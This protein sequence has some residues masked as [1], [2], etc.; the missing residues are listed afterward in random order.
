[1]EAEFATEDIRNVFSKILQFMDEEESEKEDIGQET[2][3]DVKVQRKKEEKK[4][5]KEKREQKAQEVEKKKEK[6]VSI[7]TF[8]NTTYARLQARQLAVEEKLKRN[9]KI[10]EER[11]NEQVKG[12]PEINKKSMNLQHIPISERVE[13][14]LQA[15]Q[16]KIELMTEKIQTEREKLLEKELTFQP[17]L[18]THMEKGGSNVWARMREWEE[19][20][21]MRAA[22]IK[23]NQEEKLKESL[24]FRPVIC[25]HSSKLTSDLGQKDVVLRLLEHKKT[26]AKGDCF[27]FSPE[28]SKKSKELARTRSEARVF[29]RLFTTMK[30]ESSK[31]I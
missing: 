29:D 2:R 7:G 12:K 18:S 22:I 24:T 14:V 8:Q 31:D 17:K 13:G 9:A 15:K 5:G 11:R 26:E 30:E 23:D 19:K 6:K 3:K 25:E 16:K 20:K 21:E 10:I 28:L 4:V 1:M 27:S